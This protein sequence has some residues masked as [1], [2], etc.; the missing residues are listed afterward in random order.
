MFLKEHLETV[1]QLRQTREELAET[2]ERLFK[3]QVL[4]DVLYR[5]LNGG[6]SDPWNDPSHPGYFLIM[7]GWKH[8]PKDESGLNWVDPTLVDGVAIHRTL[9]EALGVACRQLL[10][11]LGFRPAVG[12][13]EDEDTID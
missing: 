12:R 13:I 3:A 10:D 11:R 1:D 5:R 8:D 9:P 6:T 2:K 7:Q 4:V